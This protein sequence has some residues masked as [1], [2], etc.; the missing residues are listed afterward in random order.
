MSSIA[1]N[2][3]ALSKAQNADYDAQV[4]ALSTGRFKDPFSFLGAH[5]L[6]ES[7]AEVRLYLP[8][9]QSASL[10]IN[11]KLVETQR[12]KQSDLFIAYISQLPDSPYLCTAQY[13]DTSSTFFDEYSFKSELD[14]DAM[15][16]FNAVSYTHLTLPTIYSV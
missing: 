9:A 8:D 13:S 1:S 2:S 14:T 10:T 5:V 3:S 12:Y 16:L 7:N 15:Y 11:N 4:N 6:N